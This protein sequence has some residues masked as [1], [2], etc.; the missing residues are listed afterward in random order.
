MTVLNKIYIFVTI[1]GKNI[2]GAEKRFLGLWQHLVVTNPNMMLVTTQEIF[3]IQCADKSFESTVKNHAQNVLFF[4]HTSSTNKIVELIHLRKF[5]NT[6]TQRGDVL[7]FTCEFFSL[8]IL[9]RRSIYSVTHTSFALYNF[10]GKL[11]Q[12]YGI[13]IAGKVDVLDPRIYIRLQKLFFFKKKN[14]YNTTCSYCNMALFNGNFA[15]KNDVVFLGK[16]NATKQALAFVKAIPAIQ[17]ALLNIGVRISTYWILGFGEDEAQLE[18]LLLSPA[19]QSI[20]IKKLFVEDPSQLLNQSSIFV[21][22]QRY[23]NYP[24]RSLIEALAAKNIPVVTDCGDTRKLADETFSYYV[25]EQFNQ[26]D[27]AHAFVSI[28]KTEAKTLEQKRILARKHI[29]QHFTIEMMSNYYIALY[30]NEIRPIK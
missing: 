28:F 20:P 25:P 15:K 29:E 8:P 16:F 1:K 30:N 4:K 26:E 5:I 14:I 19:Y 2:G 24:S 23:S 3:D 22:L 17:E 11:V 12:Y 13:F 21:S 9:R 18:Q 6:H 7:H 10:M 27:L